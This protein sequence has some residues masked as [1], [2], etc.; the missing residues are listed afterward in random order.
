MQISVV[1]KTRRASNWVNIPVGY[2]TLEMRLPRD[3]FEFG[4]RLQPPGGCRRK[5]VFRHAVLCIDGVEK[6]D[7]KNCP[8]K[9]GNRRKQLLNYVKHSWEVFPSVTWEGDLAAQFPPGLALVP[10]R[11]ASFR[12]AHRFV[13]LRRS[14]LFRA[15]TQTEPAQRVPP[16]F[17]QRLTF[18]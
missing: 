8:P 6:R 4:I 3:H 2:A 13:R 11:Q 14:K 7:L 18:P 1:A 9:S 12:V 16:R 17:T 10:W 5:S 15:L